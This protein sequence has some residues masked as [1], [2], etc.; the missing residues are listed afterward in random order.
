MKKITGLLLV[1][2]M[3]LSPTA[4]FPDYV[5]TKIAVLDFELKGE[6]Y[7]TDDMGEIVAEWFI[8]AFVKE[9]RFDVI[10]R[11]L[12]NKILEEQKLSISGIIDEGT[13]TELGKLLGVKVI[14]SGSVLR[15]MNALEVNA[16]IIDVETA[17]IIA[18]ENVRSGTADRLKDLVDQMSVK[19]MKHFPLEGYVVSRGPEENIITID[20]GKYSGVKTGLEFQ[21]FKEG[22]VIKHPKTGEVLDVERT[23]LG[24]AVTVDVRDKIAKAQILE[25]SFTGA[26]QFGQRV[27]SVS[28][29]P[30]PGSAA[31][32]PSGATETPRPP[33]RSAA[34]VGG[35][36]VQQIVTLLRS[37]V[38]TQK[39]KGA[40]LVV[41]YYPKNTQLLAVVEDELLKGY[42]A[43]TRD[44]HYV[45]AM[46]WLCNALGRSGQTQYKDTLEEVA[47]NAE[48]RKVRGYAGKNFKRLR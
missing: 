6:G 47:K 5:K 45:Q 38:P 19:I 27:K 14:I 41:R 31:G 43:K 1:G 33:D 35:V 12:L 8:T 23:N 10:E 28:P 18:A 13:A 20:L 29:L 15:L 4:A 17:S 16:R 26:I 25:E 34:D 2:W 21:V 9:G 11:S 36:S 37:P 32:L 40:R 39:V 46:G 24:R 42:K 44:R 3:L 22:K 48:N 7:E 30:A